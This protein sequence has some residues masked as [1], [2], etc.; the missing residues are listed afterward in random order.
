MTV[1]ELRALLAEFPPNMPVCVS[2]WNEEYLPPNEHMAEC[3]T[4]CRDTVYLP[5]KKADDGS[6]PYL[7]GDFVQIGTTRL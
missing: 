6:G 3:V 2:D 7:R 1:K 4:I 5:S